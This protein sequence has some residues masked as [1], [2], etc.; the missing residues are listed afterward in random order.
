M[1]KCGRVIQDRMA[2][3]VTQSRKMANTGH[4]TLLAV[5]Q[6][7]RTT[8]IAE[9]AVVQIQLLDRLATV[10]NNKNTLVTELRFPLANAAKLVTFFE[11]IRH[12]QYLTDVSANPAHVSWT[13]LPTKTE[14]MSSQ[15]EALINSTNEILRG[16]APVPIPEP[17]QQAEGVE[18]GNY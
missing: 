6:C 15:Y 10:K 1:V 17:A 5:R 13:D 4:F 11:E 16:S 8:C 14:D 3:T 12:R 7:L 2:Q 9:A 18:V